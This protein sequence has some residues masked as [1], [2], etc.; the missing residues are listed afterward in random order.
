MALS[1]PT[2]VGG[3][4]Q[5]CP[6]LTSIVRDV[7]SLVSLQVHSLLLVANGSQLCDGGRRRPFDTTP[8]FVE[9]Q[10]AEGSVEE[11]IYRRGAKSWEAASPD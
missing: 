6:P 7:I 11:L 4:R 8:H 5:W 10:L 1:T 3:V 2:V 9:Y